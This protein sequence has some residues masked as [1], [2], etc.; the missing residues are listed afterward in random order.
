MRD[1]FAREVII[2][3]FV[4][5]ILLVL[6]GAFYSSCYSAKIFNRQNGTNYTCADF[7]WAG[8]QIN[9]QTQTIKLLK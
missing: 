5:V 7:F 4:P 3:F 8:D 1:S 2:P 6:A 9:N